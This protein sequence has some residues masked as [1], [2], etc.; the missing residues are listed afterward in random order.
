MESFGLVRER[1]MLG[2]IA[3]FIASSYYFAQ[4]FSSFFWG[5][6]SD[7]FGRRPVMLSGLI[8]SCICTFAFGFSKSLPWALTCRLLYGAFNGN[9]GVMKTFLAEMTDKTNQGK[10]F[11]YIGLSFGIGQVIGPI[12]GGYLSQPVENFPNLFTINSPLY[13]LKGFFEYFPFFLP[14]FFISTTIAIALF[15]SFFFLKE[16]NRSILKKSASTL[17]LNSINN[18]N[19][20]SIGVSRSSSFIR[21]DSLNDLKRI[22]SND[23]ELKDVPLSPTSPFTKEFD[24]TTESSFQLDLQAI[25]EKKSLFK[26][27]RSSEIIASSPPLLTVFIYTCLGINSV[28][29]S[30]I[31]PLWAILSPKRWGISFNSNDLGL[32]FTI[33]GVMI[34]IFN[35]FIVHKLISKI[36]LL[37]TLKIGSLLGIPFTLLFPEV[38]LFINL[39]YGTLLIWI[40]LMTLILIRQVTSQMQFTPI[41]IL[42]NNSVSYESMGTLNGISQSCVAL[43]RAIGPTLGGILFAMSSNNDFFPFDVH[44]VFLLMTLDNV[45]CL[46]L[47]FLLP[48][49]ISHPKSE[50]QETIHEIMME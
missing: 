4:F 38:S 36:G 32:A 47:S 40:S 34:F 17:S 29:F 24:N 19:T 42:I 15:I 2:Y 18:A 49:S 45:L 44:L 3:G 33:S 35:L 10:A 14:N 7:R 12:I 37:N 5:S 39:K 41:M 16:S 46:F 28:L 8:A 50:S 22:N 48:N 13:I 27:I 26:R 43:S 6:L 20:N 31:L 23:I 1:W 9:L 11:A 30:E 21:S 25:P